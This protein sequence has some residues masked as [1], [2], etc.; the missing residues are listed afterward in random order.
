MQGLNLKGPGPQ[1]PTYHNYI[2]SPNNNTDIQYMELFK[3][4]M[5]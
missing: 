1:S 3:G 2:D 4:Q 5:I